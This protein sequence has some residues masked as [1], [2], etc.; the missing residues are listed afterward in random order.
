[1]YKRQDYSDEISMYRLLSMPIWNLNAREYVD[2][3]KEARFKKITLLEQLE[4]LWDVKLGDEGN[5]ESSFKEVGNSNLKNIFS[6]KAIAGIGSFLLLM[7]SSI[8][9]VKDGR[10]VSDILYDFITQSSYIDS[11]L[12]KEEAEG[13]FA[14]SNIHKFLELLKQYEKL[15]N[16]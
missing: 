12:E 13:V 9:K 5:S 11:F 15:M 6:A 8:K 7:D 3:V 2:V 14:V 1:M 16:I 4:E 10:A